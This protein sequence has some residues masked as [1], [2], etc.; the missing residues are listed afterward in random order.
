[1]IRE[2]ER[3]LEIPKPVICVQVQRSV[4]ERDAGAIYTFYLFHNS[5]AK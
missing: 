4:V 1:M 3:T 5:N 2:R